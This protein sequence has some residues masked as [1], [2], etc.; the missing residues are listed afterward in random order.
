MG[1]QGNG[2]LFQ[3][4][5]NKLAKI[6]LFL[7]FFGAAFCIIWSIIFDFESSTSTHCRF[8]SKV[9]NYL[10]SIS[11]AIGGYTPQRYVWRICIALHCSPRFFITA[12]Y[13]TFN[14]QFNV[15]IRNNIY[16]FLAGLCAILNSIEILALVVLTNISSIENFSI[17][18]NSFITFM[19]T[20]ECYMLCSCIVFKW[21]RT[22][23]GR[24]MTPKEK[25]SFHYKIA[26][27]LFNI[28]CF[29]IAIYLYLRHNSYC[30][31]G[32]YSQFAFMEYLVV[33]SNIAY[34]WTMCLDFDDYVLGLRKCAESMELTIIK[35]V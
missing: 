2:L 20:S 16:K 31:A 26:L 18:E 25:K 10:P 3:I 12:G 32:V 5:I 11:S 14:T 21:G 29:F 33:L 27:F 17:H 15:G 30:E 28:S 22:S 24:Q 7:P 6:M 9:K 35:T 23:N 19:V 34:H 8:R 1:S 4:T 13:Y